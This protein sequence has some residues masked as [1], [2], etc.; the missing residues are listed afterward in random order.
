[1]KCLLEDLSVSPW[2]LLAADDNGLLPG[3][4]LVDELAVLRLGSIKLGE[5]VALVVRSDIEARQSILATD[6]EGTLDDGV[7][8]SAVHGSTA[9][10]V[11]AGSLKTSEESTD[12]VGGHED[13]GQLIVV[14]VVD[15]PEGVLLGVVVLPE[16]LKGIWGVEVGVLT[17]PLI[18]GDGGLTK[19]LAGVLG[20]GGL[21]HWLI[22]L[23]VINLLGLGLSGGLWCLRGGLSLLWGNVLQGWLI[24]EVEL[25]SNVGVDGLVVDGL[26]PTGDVGV[27]RAPGLVEEELEATGDESSAEEISKSDALAREVGVVGKVGLDNRDNLKNLLLGILNVLLVVWDTSLERLE[28]VAKAWENLGVEERHPLQDRG[29]VLLGLAKKGGLLVLGG[30]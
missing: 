13:L 24:N 5:G 15:S 1:V 10:D 6:E 29:I 20:L 25:T 30:D 2:V 3:P 27:L 26:V 19:S 11:L 22:I 16:P 28:P 17:L 14:L 9:E 8:G 7:V 4:L 18:N 12:Q 21:N 23:L